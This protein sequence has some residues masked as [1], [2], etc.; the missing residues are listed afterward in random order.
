MTKVKENICPGDKTN[1]SFSSVAFVIKS[2]IL[3]GFLFLKSLKK[4]IVAHTKFTLFLQHRATTN[5]TSTK[6]VRTHDQ[7]CEGIHLREIPSVMKNELAQ[8]LIILS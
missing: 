7:M 1:C 4:Q 3:R 6:I 8:L 5:I 2:L